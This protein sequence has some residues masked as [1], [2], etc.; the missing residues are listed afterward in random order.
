[1]TKTKLDHETEAAVTEVLTDLYNRFEAAEE[2][3]EERDDLP[4]ISPETEAALLAEVEADLE[5]TFDIKR[6]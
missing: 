1:M 4:E 5:S 3:L 6:T 2:T